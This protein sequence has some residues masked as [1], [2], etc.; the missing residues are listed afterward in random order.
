MTLDELRKKR[1]AKIETTIQRH[2][3]HV[4]VNIQPL[5][6]TDQPAV[7]WLENQPTKIG[8][9]GRETEFKFISAIDSKSFTVLRC[10]ITVT[11]F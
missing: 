6:I 3:Q 1:L 9:I 2:Q 10:T 7:M 5:R 4:S 11:S 8:M